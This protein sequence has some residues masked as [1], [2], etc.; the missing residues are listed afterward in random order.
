MSTCAGV[1]GIGHNKPYQGDALA[2]LGLGFAN[3]SNSI[4]IRHP[5]VV[6]RRQ[7]QINDFAVKKHLSPISLLPVIVKLS[8]K[9]VS[10][11]FPP[12]WMCVNEMNTN[13]QGFL[14]L[15]KGAV[16]SGVLWAFSR[17]SELVCSSTG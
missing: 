1:T 10:Y 7:C 6:L 8:A 15:W 16:G 12:A 3:F 17:V 2:A 5:C 11:L 4:I 14:S 13:L 9:D